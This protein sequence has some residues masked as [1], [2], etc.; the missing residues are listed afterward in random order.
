M[1]KLLELIRCLYGLSRFYVNVVNQSIRFM[2]LEVFFV[3]II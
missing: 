3:Q 1:N 2:L